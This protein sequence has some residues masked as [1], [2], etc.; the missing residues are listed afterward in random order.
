MFFINLKVFVGVSDRGV[1]N[2]PA[3]VNCVPLI[4]DGDAKVTQGLY[5]FRQLVPYIQSERSVLY[6]LHEVLVVGGYKLGERGS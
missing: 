2:Q 3:K 4:P 1:L 6:S 5:W